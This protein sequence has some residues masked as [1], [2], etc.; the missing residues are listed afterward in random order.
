VGQVQFN[1]CRASQAQTL[2]KPQLYVTLFTA[3]SFDDD[4][5]RCLKVRGK[6]RWRGIRQNN[7]W[8]VMTYPVKSDRWMAIMRTGQTAGPDSSLT[9]L[10]LTA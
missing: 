7:G 10:E 3:H 6:G 9:V 1:V 8:L 4:V 2:G 5:L